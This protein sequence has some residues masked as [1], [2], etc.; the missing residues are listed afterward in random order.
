MACDASDTIG[1]TFYSYMLFLDDPVSGF[2]ISAVRYY[3]Q[4]VTILPV[5]NLATQDDDLYY[6][7]ECAWSRT[8]SNATTAGVAMDEFFTFVNR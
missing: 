2:G 3:L 5:K 6:Q 1:G 4:S 7:K 8:C